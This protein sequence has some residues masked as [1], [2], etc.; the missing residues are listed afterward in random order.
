MP[1]RYVQVPLD[2]YLPAEDLA[3]ALGVS[4]A[5]LRQ[6]N[7]AVQATIWTG[8]KH[9]PKGYTVRLPASTLDGDV[10]TLLASIPESSWADRQLPDLYH[11][12]ARGDTLSQIA[13]EYDT[14]VST[15]VA[16][17]NLGSR[18]RIR[19]GQRLRLPAAGPAPVPSAAP[20]VASAAAPEEVPVAV[21]AEEE[22]P[23]VVAAA[24]DEVTAGAE[25]L[26]DVE[27]AE[28][29]ALGGEVVQS[30]AAAVQTALL[31]DPS[32]YS[33]ADDLTI[34]VQPLETLGHYADWLGIRTQ[35]LRDVNGFAFR[36]PVVVGQ[37]IR[38]VIDEA[39]VP[40]FEARRIAYHRNQQDRYFREHV[41]TGITQH[42]VRR[43]ES[44]W[45]LSLRQYGVPLWL[46]RQY[47]PELDLDRIQPGT[48]VNFPVLSDADRG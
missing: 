10:D 38:L 8:S 25:P 4:T 40:D 19:A 43:G 34:E 3:R 21:E 29:A 1:T 2:G 6:H 28:P 24:V 27:E 20:A 46:F 17:N 26:A 5:T 32:D 30:P 47:N 37:R 42:E 45:I 36:T 15:L 31:S 13:E 11:T 9:F 16:L 33:V 18:H 41:I 7:P 48:S 35:R 22:E 44:I 39:Q 12:I 14:R 23:V